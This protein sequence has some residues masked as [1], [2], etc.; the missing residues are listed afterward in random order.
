[1]AVVQYIEVLPQVIA[2]VNLG[3]ANTYSTTLSDDRYSL[4][5]IEEVILLTDLEVRRE[6]ARSPRN[7]HWA[8]MLTASSDL[9]HRAAVPEHEGV[10]GEVEIKVNEDDTTYIPPKDNP[11]TP[12]DIE[13]Y[14]ENP[15]NC[16]GTSAHDAA[17]SPIAGCFTMRSQ[18]GFLTGYR[19]RVYYIPPFTIDRATPACQSPEDCT[20][21]VVRGSVAKL[22]KEGMQN[23]ELF[24]KHYAEFQN[25]LAD[26]HEGREVQSLAEAA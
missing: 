26:I 2:R 23:P 16:F 13:M 19:W 1:M 12:T 5:E 24:D 10:L 4:G 9:T 20:A 14:R 17:S 7:G 22:K 25:D 21:T 11:V 6:I 3:A 8:A 18:R 15:D